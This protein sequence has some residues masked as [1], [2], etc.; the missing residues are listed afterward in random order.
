MIDDYKARRAGQVRPAT[1]NRELVLLK[2][3]FNKAV[4]WGLAD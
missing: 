3:L 4:T 1:V 2:T